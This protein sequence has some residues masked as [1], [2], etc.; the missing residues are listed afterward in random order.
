MAATDPGA[1]ARERPASW[2]VDIYT[3]K[4]IYRPG[5]TV[6][7]R[8]V[9]RWRERDALRPFDRP[10][11]EIVVSDENDKVLVRRMLKV[12]TFGA[13]SA[14][15]AIPATGALG[16]YRVLLQSG[17][18]Q[19]ATSFPVQEYRK[20]EFEVIV[21]PA[22]RFVLQG[23][24]AVVSVDARYYFGQPVANGRLHWVVSQ[25]PYE[26]PLRF[27][28]SFEGDEGG[29]FTGDDQTLQGDLR[30]DNGRPRSGFSR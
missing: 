23:D 11:V 17:D 20:P 12:D 6:H 26:S 14:S 2:S 7:T 3:D 27:D 10:E 5:Q 21:T 15:F 16:F 19:A 30:L 13:V 8:G 1:G 24:E 29:Y 25:Q 18:A 4:S 28:E 22:S 9:L